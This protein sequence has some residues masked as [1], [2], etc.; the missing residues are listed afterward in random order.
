MKKIKCNCGNDTFKMLEKQ[1]EICE[2]NGVW[3]EE[4]DRYVYIDASK[5]V[6]RTQAYDEFECLK[7]DNF[8]NGCWTYV[9]TECGEESIIPRVEE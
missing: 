3:S 7:G 5:K 1:C 6:F 2:H 8:G 4:E 9:C